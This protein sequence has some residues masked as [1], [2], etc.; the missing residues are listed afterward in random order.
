MDQRSRDH[1]ELNVRTHNNNDCFC[2]NNGLPAKK[3]AVRSELMDLVDR[4]S[5]GLMVV[6]LIVGLVVGYVIPLGQIS[7][8]ESE[9]ADLSAR[10]EDLETG[11]IPVSVKILKVKDKVVPPGSGYGSFPPELRFE[12]DESPLFLG[13]HAEC[14]PTYLPLEMDV[15]IQYRYYPKDNRS[16]SWT[17][18]ENNV[19]GL[20]FFNAT[21]IWPLFNATAPRYFAEYITYSVHNPNSVDMTVSFEILV[22]YA[23][24]GE[25]SVLKKN[26]DALERSYDNLMNAHN[27]LQSDHATLS[28]IMDR[29]RSLTLLFLATTIVF[30]VIGVYLGKRSIDRSNV[31]S[32]G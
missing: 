23:V 21:L 10:Y 13:L 1:H 6:F 15:S 19:T 25:S 28:T 3:K 11:Y 26:Y 7:Q 17:W 5:V 27:A 30:V 31:K 16:Y 9:F 22:Y 12:E 2:S 24:E 8:L 18:M 29:F 20:D 14:V 32:D 4:K